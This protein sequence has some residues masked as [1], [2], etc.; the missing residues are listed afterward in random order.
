MSETDY[1]SL[2]RT[3]YDSSPKAVAVLDIDV[4]NPANVNGL[5]V[6]Y[7]N[8]RFRNDYQIQE[9][10]ENISAVNLPM[11]A[12]DMVLNQFANVTL[13]GVQS[14]FI[15]SYQPST[16]TQWLRYEIVKQDHFLIV[17]TF[18]ISDVRKV[19]VVLENALAEAE[20]QRRLYDSI[21]NNTPDLIYVFDLDYRIT[22]ANKA[23]LD[24]WGKPAEDS[25]GKGLRDNG[26]E[27]WHAEMHEREID[28]VVANKKNIRG[29][30][31]FPHA[32]LGERVYDYILVPVLNENGEVEAVA[33]TTR[34]I[35]EFRQSEQKI[36]QSETRLKMMIDQTPAPTLVL[37]GDRL[38]IEQIN[39]PM[40]QMIGQDESVI[41]L[42]LI[43]V[44][45]ELK[46]SFIWQKVLKVYDDGV[47]YEH[48]EVLVSHKRNAGIEDFYYNLSYR[49]LKDGDEIVGMI[50]VAVDVTE[51]VVGRKKMEESENK[52][53]KLSETLEQQVIKRT[54][55]LQRSNEDLQQFAHVASHDL[56]EPVRKI[57]IFAGRMEESI[58]RQTGNHDH[59]LS[60]YID[61]IEGAAD[62][63]HTMIEGVLAYST[64]NATSREPEPVDL[65]LVIAN[66][67]IDLEVALQ[68]ASGKIDRGALPVVE[69]APVLLYQLFYNLINNSLKFAR[70]DVA[71]RISVQS[72][73]SGTS[74][75]ITVSDNGIGFSDNQSSYI[76]ETFHRLHS[77]DQYEGTGLGLSLC[78]KIVER[79]GGTISATGNPGHGATFVIHLPLKQEEAV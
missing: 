44:L 22:Y 32:E 67:E 51:H 60:G 27:E 28:D 61:K 40:L 26:Y 15:A 48:P 37:M 52:Y 38:V 64:V 10:T 34:D 74:V 42:P 2:F 50:Q 46:G 23:L 62:R 11:F 53:R 77:K 25:I 72:E 63:M 45:P 5:T 18:D 19:E 16:T 73:T 57:K 35:T 6:R 13:T 49:P 30:V 59:S 71:P 7:L 39:K 33:G 66:I 76:F 4:E 20:K 14:Q 58:K 79:H 8:V 21:T 69:G 3:L 31:S 9:T 70:P 43:E 1:I 24:M 12:Q 41:G 54:Q 55:E 78:K 68:N 65:N 75:N 56:K 29:T 17:S 47:P 36:R